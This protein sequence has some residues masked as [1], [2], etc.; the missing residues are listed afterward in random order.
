MG[1]T[2][3][4]DLLNCLE[5]KEISDK[6]FFLF[7]GAPDVVIND[8]TIMV[9][10]KRVDDDSLTSEDELVENSMHAE[11]TFTGCIPPLSA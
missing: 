11:T 2:W 10:G 5:V 6:I 9:V 1:P 7:R 8:K 4:T 3:S